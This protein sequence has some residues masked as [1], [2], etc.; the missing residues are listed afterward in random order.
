MTDSSVSCRHDER[1]AHVASLT[2]QFGN[3]QQA[4]QE[5][6]AE[7]ADQ[8]HAQTES[9][10]QLESS[11]QLHGELQA[12]HT[13]QSSEVVELTQQLS[14][15]NGAARDLQVHSCL[16]CIC[17]QAVRMLHKHAASNVCHLLYCSCLQLCTHFSAIWLLMGTCLFRFICAVPT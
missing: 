2:E 12:L 17:E 5:L 15:A 3:T 11:R 14:S 7:F 10:T 8:Q 4:L 1:A 9:K 13:A 16:Q 6:Q